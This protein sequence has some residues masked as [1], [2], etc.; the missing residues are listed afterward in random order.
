VLAEKGDFIACAPE[1]NPFRVIFFNVFIFTHQQVPERC[2][3]AR[4][5]SITTESCIGTAPI[6]RY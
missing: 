5:F 2:C 3:Y 6:S 4:Q 1:R